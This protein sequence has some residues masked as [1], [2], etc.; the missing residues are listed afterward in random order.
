MKR[1]EGERNINIYKYYIHIN[2]KY[3]Y[4]VSNILKKVCIYNIYY[5]VCKKV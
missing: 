3:I 4:I 2:Q 5:I 1:E